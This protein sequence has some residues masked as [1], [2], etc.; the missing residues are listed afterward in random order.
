MK[1]VDIA[2]EIYRELASPVDLSI[3]VIAFWIRTNIGELNNLL[4]SNFVLDVPSLEIKD[5]NGAEIPPEAVAVLKKIYYIHNF[6]LEIKKHILSIASDSILEV[7]DQ[8]SSIK[9]IN[10]NE[11][12]K[13][14]GSLRRQEYRALMK[15]TS[16]YGIRKSA[17]RQVTEGGSVGG[18]LGQD[19]IE[20]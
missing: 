19:V 6:D 15:L 13:T 12:T 16:A 9:R 11:V 7:T 18:S 8:G 10:K 1:V 4:Y 5:E 3:S 2:D 14:L 17:P 20:N